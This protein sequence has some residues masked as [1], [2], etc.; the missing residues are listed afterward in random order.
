MRDLPKKGARG[1]G[2]RRSFSSFH[3]QDRLGGAGWKREEG[4]SAAEF[5]SVAAAASFCNQSSNVLVLDSTSKYGR[6]SVK[7]IMFHKS[8]ILFVLFG[9][10]IGASSAVETQ[11]IDEENPEIHSGELDIL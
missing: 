11:E 10:A 6:M 3:R 9:L 2:R 7:L 5:N 4:E 1:G 8:S